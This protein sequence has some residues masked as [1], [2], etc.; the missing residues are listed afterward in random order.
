[1]V[2]M[3]MGAAATAFFKWVWTPEEEVKTCK[4]ARVCIWCGQEGH[5]ATSCKNTKTLTLTLA[6][7]NRG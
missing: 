3:A 4:T 7:D 6:F 2:N 5:T 1:M